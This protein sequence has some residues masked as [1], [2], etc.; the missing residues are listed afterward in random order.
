VILATKT[1]KIAWIR[2]KIGYFSLFAKKSAE[3]ICQYKKKYYLCT[4]I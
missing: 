4:R 2:Q 1:T 3:K